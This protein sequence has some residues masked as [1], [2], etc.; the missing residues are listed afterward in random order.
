MI[1]L[2]INNS[3]YMEEYCVITFRKIPEGLDEGIFQKKLLLWMDASVQ[4]PIRILSE[5]EITVLYKGKKKNDRL[6]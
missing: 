3:Q 6:G 2:I 1:P 4:M 5:I